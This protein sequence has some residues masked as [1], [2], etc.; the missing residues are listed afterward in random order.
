MIP[1]I[2]SSLQLVLVLVEII[3][4]QNSYLKQQDYN[5]KETQGKLYLLGWRKLIL[6]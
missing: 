4:K 5:Y 3:K 6:N 2:E 1:K